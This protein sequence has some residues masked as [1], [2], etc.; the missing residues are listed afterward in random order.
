V[1]HN[2]IGVFSGKG[3]VGKTTVT[4]NLA[5]AFSK[6]N[7][8][9]VAIDTDIKMTGLGLQLGMYQFQATLNDVLL[10]QKNIHEALYIHPSGIR[11]IPAALYQ[12]DVNTE[13]I[14]QVLSSSFF[15]NT[16]VFVDSPPGL[17]RNATD[18]LKAC[19]SGIL[20]VTPD[21][22]SIV[23]GAKIVSE[24]RE[25]N[26]QA[27]GAVVNMYI[28]N[29]KSQLSLSEIESFLDIPIL[30]CVPYDKEVRRSVFHRTSAIAH[31]PYS[32]AS[33]EFNK[34]ATKLLGLNYE[35]DNLAWAK[36]ILRG[37]KR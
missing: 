10:S 29:D 36:N 4:V 15:R 27:L 34:I 9:V 32:P 5:T 28:R 16:F 26:C 3:G 17:E 1:G 12:Q 19:P 31:N 22:P 13:K 24:M 11:I 6:F 25:A 8:N 35:V 30:G 2:I 20:V 18:V 7:K 33:I 21:T 14:K 37:L 23:D